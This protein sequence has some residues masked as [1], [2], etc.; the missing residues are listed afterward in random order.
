MKNIV[1]I[2][3]TAFG[4]FFITIST[5]AQ[6]DN[7]ESDTPLITYTIATEKKNLNDFDFVLGNWNFYTPDGTL[8]GEQT[9]TKREQGHL[10]LE[11]WKLNSGSTGLGM[12]Y[13]DPKTGLWRQVWMSPMFHIDYSG[14]LDEN[15]VMVLEGVLYPNNG[16]KSSPIRGLWAKQ[17]D[18]SIKQEFLVL[19]DK[20]KTWDILFAGFTR[21]KKD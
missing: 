20:T 6:T 14:G 2:G 13:L 16:D 18:G 11:E 5:V 3:F 10:I 9:Y 7:N 8:I 21:L 1:R 12:T 19:N 15:G 17:A 4:I